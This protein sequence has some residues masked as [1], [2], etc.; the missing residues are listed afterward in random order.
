MRHAAALCHIEGGLA[1]ELGDIAAQTTR[2]ELLQLLKS[3]FPEFDVIRAE[4][5]LKT[6]PTIL[7]TGIDEESGARLLHALKGLK[8]PARLV[9]YRS[10]SWGKRLWN[11]GLVVSAISLFLAAIFRGHAAFLFVLIAGGAP[12][13]AAL[14][15]EHRRKPLLTPEDSTVSAINGLLYLKSTPRSLS[16]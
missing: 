14:L 12:L 9:D 15:A 13:A 7:M 3:W 4:H 10:E 2:A 16:P 5:R 8:I 1:L 11:S 6:G